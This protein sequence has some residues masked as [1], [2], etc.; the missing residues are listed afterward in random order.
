LSTRSTSLAASSSTSIMSQ[1]GHPAGR[2]ISRSRRRCS[3]PGS[4]DLLELLD[5]RVATRAT[6]ITSKLPVTTWDEWLNDPTLANAI[7]DRIMHSA[8]KIALKG[9]SM[10]KKQ[11]SHERFAH[12]DACRRRGVKH[13]LSANDTRATPAD[14]RGAG[15]GRGC[16]SRSHTAWQCA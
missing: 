7:L 12:P 5:D 4:H 6:L 15:H 9:E 3:W 16:R 10:R 8:H 14:A 11:P 13:G 2:Q 1:H